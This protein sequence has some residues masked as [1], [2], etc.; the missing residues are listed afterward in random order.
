MYDENLDEMLEQGYVL[1]KK[2]GKIEVIEPPMYGEI[3]L[4]IQ[5]RKVVLITEVNNRKV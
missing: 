2:N 4:K 5:D 1:Y 3:N